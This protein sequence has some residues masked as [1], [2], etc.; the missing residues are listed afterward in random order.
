[1]APR[2]MWK[3][4]IRIAEL[5]FPISLYAGATV[6]KRI[7]F[8]I[9]NRKTGNRV[10]R[11]Y[12]DDKTGKPVDRDHQVKGYETG[13]G[14]YLILQ[15]EEIAA[16]LPDSDK[17][18]S[19]EHF[20]PS[21]NVDTVFFDKPYYLAGNDGIL[22]ESF[23]VL[24]EGMLRQ[25]VVAVA[26]AVLFKRHR[27]LILKPEG[28]GFV[29][30]TLNF[31][32]EVRA[33]SEVFDALPK[34]KIEAEMLDL[35]KHIIETKKGAFDPRLFDDHYD[36]ALAELIKA[37]AEGRQIKIAKLKREEKVVSLMEALR[38]SA[39]ASKQAKTGASTRRKAS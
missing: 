22:G 4:Y 16:A 9:I 3:G 31:D 8:H 7:S 33:A 34:V 10:S 39:K 13:E 29:A 15:P 32:Y 20:V 5:A 17:T 6:S 24:R 18:I 30:H 37:K 21:T 26:R 36:L 28:T 11:Q 35:A 1:M 27:T 12:I 14:E 19:I 23:T 38:E 25:K 2:A